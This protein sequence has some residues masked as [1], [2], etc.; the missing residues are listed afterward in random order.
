MRK[1]AILALFVLLF[2]MASAQRNWIGVSSPS[3]FGLPSGT[4]AGLSL[5]PGFSL[6]LSGIVGF[7]RLIGALDLRAAASLSISGGSFGMTLG[8]DVLYP[9]NATGDTVYFGGGPFLFLGGGSAGFALQ[10]AVGYESFVARNWSWFVELNP[11]FEFSSSTFALTGKF[12]IN[13]YL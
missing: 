6:G 3:F 2:S 4:G 1:F 8:A 11:L 12:G 7:E 5:V 10:G 9:L 13:V